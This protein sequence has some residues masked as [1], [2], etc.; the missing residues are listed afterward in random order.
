[1]RYR[2]SV[3]YG[4]PAIAATRALRFS[5]HVTK[6]N[7]ECGGFAARAIVPPEGKARLLSLAK[8]SGQG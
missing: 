6:R 5:D 7:E 3:I 4:H 8:R 1:M 2:V